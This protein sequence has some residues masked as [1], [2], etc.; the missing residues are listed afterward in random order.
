[1]KIAISGASGFIG[2]YLNQYFSRK[3]NIIFPL[4][5]KI[6]TS[7]TS[8][9]LADIL[10]QCDVVINIAGAS[11]NHRWTPAYKKELID[12]RIITTRKIVKTINE[13]KNKPQL[14]ISAS[15]VGYYPSQGCYDEVNAKQGN[16]FLS[17]LCEQWEQEA[18]AVSSDVRLVL[19]R[20]GV[21]LSPQGGAF[22]E[23]MRPAQLG[24]ATII[25]PG[26][27]HFPWI[28]IADLA[29]AM[30]HLINHTDLN[31]VVNLVAPQSITNKEL[32]QAAANHYHSL[33]TIK[34][35][36]FI[37]RIIFGEAS[38][39]MTEGQCVMPKKLL[40]SGF[41]FKSATITD[42]FANLL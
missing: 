35:P 5:R 41:I 14:L 38:Q 33:L 11:I 29:H 20:L 19:T 13:I 18:Q 12:S 24:L 32:M 27:Q 1:M 7:E 28:D 8:S 4:T 34:I 17:Q 26:T 25:G 16:S 37:F 15:A 3:D 6:L 10:T 42:F 36:Q 31:G 2:N 9:E 22:K 39:F 40:D 21:V 30:E 23:M